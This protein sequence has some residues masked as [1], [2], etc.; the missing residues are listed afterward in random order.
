MGNSPTAYHGVAA[1]AEG[2]LA[3]TV[4]PPTSLS[5]FV[6]AM[7]VVVCCVEAF[8]AIGH[9]VILDDSLRS[10]LPWGTCLLPTRKHPRNNR[11]NIDAR[12][13]TTVLRSTSRPPIPLEYKRRGVV[14]LSRIHVLFQQYFCCRK[15]CIKVPFRP[16]Q[17][18][19][20]TRKHPWLVLWTR[21]RL[22]LA[23]R[24]L[25]VW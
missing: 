23:L 4:D 2:S 13:Y 14:E 5:G 8:L 22:Y 3:S 20:T 10:S 21:L 17:Y 19:V 16:R 15:V 25:C 9:V 6:F 24:S 7:C 1:D 11:I 12:F 18:T